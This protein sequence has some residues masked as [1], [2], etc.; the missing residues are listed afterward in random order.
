MKEKILIENGTIIDGTGSKEY[1]GNIIIEDNKIVAIGESAKDFSKEKD[2]K[3][4]DASE[5]FVMPGIIDA[6]CHISFDEPTS[7]DELFFHRRQALAAIISGHNARKVLLAGVTGF[8]DPDSLHEIGIDLRDAINSGYVEGPRMSVGG[9]AL[10]TS[11]GGT[12]GRL[13]TD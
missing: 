5:K 3:K 2:I 8:C 12:A 7:N 6:H 13:I 4:I 9:N 10:L 11:V 1:I